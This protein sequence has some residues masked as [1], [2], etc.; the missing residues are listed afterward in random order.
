MRIEAA[1]LQG[2]LEASA[3]LRILLLRHVHAFMVRAN[4]TALTNGHGRM[5][6]RLAR[7][8]LMSHDRFKGDELAVTHE[9][10][11]LMLGV[12]RQGVTVALHVLEGM[13][14]IR[15]TRA[16]I[17]VL[18]RK[19]LIELASGSYGK[20]EAEYERLIGHYCE[21]RREAQ[22]PYERGEPTSAPG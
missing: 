20:C 22:S 16:H 13:G 5:V 3:T 11:A 1:A 18:N 6:E 2:A 15:S 9:F 4:Q 12:R 17:R 10:V 7:W 14:L 19:G 8:I 21:H